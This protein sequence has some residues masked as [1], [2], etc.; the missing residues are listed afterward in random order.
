VSRRRLLGR[1]T[2]RRLKHRSLA[3]LT[4]VGVFAWAW[5]THP[6]GLALTLTA[7][8]LTAGLA[9][10]ARRARHARRLDADGQTTVVYQHWFRRDLVQPYL[11][12]GYPPSWFGYTGITNSYIDRCGQ[13]AEGSWWW[14]L[15]DP[16]LSTVATYPNRY[17]AAQAETALI[18][19]RCG[20]GNT[21]DNPAFRRQADLRISLQ[22]Y[23][24]QLHQHTLAYGRTG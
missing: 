24:L 21:R 19:E 13:H 20:V 5:Q 1:R 3:I 18:R 12:A 17:A 2:R 9:L 22:A 15:I 4:V 6:L 16:N 11:D 7:A 10:Y 23:A 8:T 14:I